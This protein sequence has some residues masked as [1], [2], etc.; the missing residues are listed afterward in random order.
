MSNLY[1]RVTVVEP[2]MPVYSI[3]LLLEGLDRSLGDLSPRSPE[4]P[5]YKKVISAYAGSLVYNGFSVDDL[6][7]SFLEFSRWI[8]NKGK[9]VSSDRAYDLGMLHAY[10]E[11]LLE[12]RS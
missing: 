10:L 2:V 11:I 12:R 3:D 7:E 4:N 1:L 5:S 9:E 6:K 8:S